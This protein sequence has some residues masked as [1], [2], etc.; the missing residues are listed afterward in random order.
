MG[1]APGV[2]D[3]AMPRM[4]AQRYMRKMRS[5]G[6]LR[7][8]GCANSNEAFGSAADADETHVAVAVDAL[9]QVAVRSVG[10]A[11][12][13]VAVAPTVAPARA[14]AETETLVAPRRSRGRSERGG[15]EGGE[16]GEGEHGL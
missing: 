6:L 9:H 16:S 15:A 1:L 11:R 2:P 14:E 7:D 4:R 3:R 12:A 13:V 5:P 8:R 10:V